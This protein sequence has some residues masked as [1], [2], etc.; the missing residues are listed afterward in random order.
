MYQW[1]FIQLS[2]A[3]LGSSMINIDWVM[4]HLTLEID[5]V[6]ENIVDPDEMPHYASFHLGLEYLPK[7]Q[8]WCS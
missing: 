3:N 6:L 5:L 2:S 1:N 8:F 7:Y 4:G